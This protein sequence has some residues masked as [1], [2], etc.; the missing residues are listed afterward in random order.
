MTMRMATE[1]TI[2]GL[3]TVVAAV[4]DYAVQFDFIKD[5]IAY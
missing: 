2:A 1:T 4:V 3:G 5:G